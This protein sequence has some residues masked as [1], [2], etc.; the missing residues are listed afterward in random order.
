M[1]GAARQGEHVGG[2]GGPFDGVAAHPRRHDVV[3][4]A[5]AEAEGPREQQRRVE[6]EGS[7]LG[8]PPDERGQ[9][10][11][12]AGRRQLLLRL[13]P[14]A[15]QE[16]VGRS[17]EDDDER[18]GDQAEDADRPGDD[19]GRP[20]GGRDA[21]ELRHQLTGDHRAHGGDQHGDGRREGRDR[22]L[23][24]ADRVERT[25][26][27]PADRWL[28]EIA[29]EQGGQRDADLRRGQLGGQASQRDE[30]GLGARVP[31]IDGSLDGGPVEGNVVPLAAEPGGPADGRSRATSENSAAT[32]TAAA[33]VS[34]TAASSRSHS[35]IVRS[36]YGRG[37]TDP[38]HRRPGGAAGCKIG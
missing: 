15:P 22:R 37:E 13:D 31:G 16:R 24:D 30:D 28:G 10:L 34:A 35:V 18:L 29:G 2:A 36:S 8:R 20:E 27:Q 5:L 11:R 19:L 25:T 14:D 23:R 3:G 9:L 38:R 1:A 33:A 17:V 21:E 4:G 32:N 6:V 12:G 7:G 26:D